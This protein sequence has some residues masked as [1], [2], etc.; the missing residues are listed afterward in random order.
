MRGR[1]ES[2]RA[3]SLADAVFPLLLQ[4]RQVALTPRPD[5]HLHQIMMFRLLS[6]QAT[7]REDQELPV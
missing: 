6:L 2:A 7:V 3:K 5:Q 4:I 1:E